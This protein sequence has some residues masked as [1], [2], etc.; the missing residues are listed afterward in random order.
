MNI[1]ISLK[2]KDHYRCVN[3]MK[4]HKHI[5]NSQK[6]KTVGKYTC[7]NVIQTQ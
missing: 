4:E 7:Y 6:S 1:F 2:L 5:T 3:G